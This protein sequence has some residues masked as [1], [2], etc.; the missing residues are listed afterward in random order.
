[1]NDLKEKKNFLYVYK[2]HAQHTDIYYVD[3]LKN[4]YDIQYSSI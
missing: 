2:S 4:I 1:M 3:I